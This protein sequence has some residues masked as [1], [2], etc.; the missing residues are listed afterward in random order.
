MAPKFA[1]VPFQVFFQSIQNAFESRKSRAQRPD[2]FHANH[3]ITDD[4]DRLSKGQA[5]SAR[6]TALAALA[7]GRLRTAGRPAGAGTN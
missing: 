4:V 2:L 5:S 3:D 7:D 1:F 6:S